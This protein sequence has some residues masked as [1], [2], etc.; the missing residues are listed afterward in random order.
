MTIVITHFQPNI[1]SYSGQTSLDFSTDHT[2][3][4]G[5]FCDKKKIAYVSAVLPW[6]CDSTTIIKFAD[7]T[8]V[9]GLMISEVTH[10]RT[11]AKT[12]FWFGCQQ[13]ELIVGEAGEIPPGPGVDGYLKICILNALQN[14]HCFGVSFV[15]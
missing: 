14:V 7:D 3:L 15:Q 9:A 12:T 6:L 8:V 11:G 13:D 1:R 5:T 2:C 10:L 4:K